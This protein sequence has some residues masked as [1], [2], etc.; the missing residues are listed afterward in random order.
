MKNGTV[1]HLHLGSAI[2]IWLRQTQGASWFVAARLEHFQQH[3]MGCWKSY[4]L[5]AFQ[6]EDD[7]YSGPIKL[8]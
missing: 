8:A 4:D 2:Y 6:I 5:M 3:D 1:L 7:L